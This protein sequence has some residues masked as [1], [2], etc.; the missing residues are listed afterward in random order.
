MP[1][2]WTHFELVFASSGQAVRAITGLRTGLLGISG[3]T[4]VSVGWGET[5]ER[6]PMVLGGLRHDVL[7]V[8]GGAMTAIRSN[9]FGL[10]SGWISSHGETD[11]LDALEVS[12]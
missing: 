8:R 6:Q 4:N 9:W 2:Y 11:G 5:D 3:V 7:A 12:F 1:R 10:Q